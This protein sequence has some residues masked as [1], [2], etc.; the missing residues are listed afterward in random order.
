[1]NISNYIP[2]SWRKPIYG[3]FAVIGVLL[4]AAQVGIA[5]VGE[6]NPDWLLV[7]LAVFPF[8]AGA[9]GFTASANT[10]STN[11]DIDWAGG[12]MADFAASDESVD[13]EDN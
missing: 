3:A 11:D 12:S 10:N 4:G 2:A 8:L 1:M 13:L 9:I 5:A 6:A 7:V